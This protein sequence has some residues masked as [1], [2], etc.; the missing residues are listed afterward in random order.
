MDIGVFYGG[1]VLAAF[2]AGGIALFAPCCISVMAYRLGQ[3]RPSGPAS[4][5]AA[6]V[7]NDEALEAV[8]RR[9]AEG[10]IEREEFERLR[11]DLT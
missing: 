2:I 5:R 11:R 6:P 8:R 4:E 3:D 7:R 10:E 1:S 9:Y